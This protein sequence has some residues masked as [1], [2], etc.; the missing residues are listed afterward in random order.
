M[1]P[2]VVA[3]VIA[4]RFV[5]PLLI[6]RFP[7]PA[8][9]AALVIDAADQTIF[10]AVLDEPLA[11]YQAYD[12]ALDIYYLTIAYCATMRNWSDPVAFGVARFLFLY[13]LAGVV[14]FETLHQRWLLLVFPNTFE[15]FFI[16]YEAIATRWNPAR[17]KPAA[18]VSLALGIWVF[19]KLPQETWLHVAK[20]DVTDVVQAHPWVLLIAAGAVTAAAVALV[21]QW[22]WLPRP[23][24]PFTL[25]AGRRV[26]EVP[27]ER[28]RPSLRDGVLWEKVILLALICVIF[29]NVLPGIEAG[30]VGIAV[31][32]GLLVIVNAFV[33]EL[34]YRRGR[35]WPNATR[36][37]SAMLV[38]N[39][40]ILVADSLLGPDSD[41]VPTAA[42]L[43]FVVL[44]SLLIALF[45]RMRATRGPS[46]RRLPARLAFEL[47]RRRAPQPGLPQPPDGL[48]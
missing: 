1:G 27:I 3:V 28:R 35:S 29:A 21:P 38:I 23:D 41:D 37:F 43:A 39:L 12:K 48:T 44:L 4:A 25:D 22:R 13:R 6:P 9:V 16:A 8:V 33:S 42:N 20:L 19:V 34:W 18:V 24:H 32:A 47:W 10:D 30:P 36:A 15:Y 5:V 45:D 26:P 31:G 7:L 46:D 2:F 11:G 40:A 14:L 17:L